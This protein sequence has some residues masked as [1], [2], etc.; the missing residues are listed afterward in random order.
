[1]ANITKT[2]A[3][4]DNAVVLNKTAGVATQTIACDTADERTAI[5]IENTSAS[6][7]A[8]VTVVAGNGMRSSIG[9]L[10]VEVAPSSEVVVGPLDSM[11]FK[12]LDDGTIT[13]RISGG[14][15]KIK[16]FAL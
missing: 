3:K 11:R 4:R 2:Y 10:E 12:N 7:A 1:M 16:P 8:T 5:I 15:T 14:E 6:E 9:D 13:V